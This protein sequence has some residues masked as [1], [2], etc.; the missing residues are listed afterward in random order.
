MQKVL[1]KVFGILT[2]V[3]AA[4]LARSLMESS[5]KRTHAGANPP[6]QP[7]APGTQWGEALTWAVASGVAAGV[8]R[9]LAT[10]SVAS[11]WRKATGHLPPGLEEVGN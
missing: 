11:A 3:L 6:R 2:G 5:W 9:L 4:K 7:D 10:K 8:A 1:Y